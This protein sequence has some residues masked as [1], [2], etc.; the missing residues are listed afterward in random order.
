ML[1]ARAI[2]PDDSPASHPGSTV[3]RRRPRSRAREAVQHGRYAVVHDRPEALRRV[4]LEVRHRHFARQEKRDRAGKQAEQEQASAKYFE[5]AADPHLGHQRGCAAGRRHAD[6]ERKELHR[7]RLD[8]HERGHYAQHAP[9]LRRPGRPRRDEVR[10][11]HIRSSCARPASAR[12]RWP[13]A[14][15]ARRVGAARAARARSRVFIR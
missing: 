12:P 4:E 7:A 1:D 3:P 15:R 10:C 2:H 9:Q 11:A 14:N 6:R 8:E 5:D 13:Q